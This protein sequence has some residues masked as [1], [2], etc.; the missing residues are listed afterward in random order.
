MM[1]K[2]AI[3]QILVNMGILMQTMMHF[4][5]R[6]FFNQSKQNKN[7]QDVENEARI[8]M[9]DNIATTCIYHSVPN[10]TDGSNIFLNVRSTITS[11]LQ[12]SVRVQ[13]RNK[14]SL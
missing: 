12:I 9:K 8:M 13:G 3:M 11:R 6:F 10:T 5:C 7:I 4:K 1:K 2:Y 14:N